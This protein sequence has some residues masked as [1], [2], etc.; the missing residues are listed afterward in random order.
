MTGQGLVKFSVFKSLLESYQITLS[1][2]EKEAIMHGFYLKHYY[3]GD[4]LLA[5]SQVKHGKATQQ[6]H[7]AYKKVD[8]SDYEENDVEDCSGYLGMT[9]R[10]K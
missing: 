6:L 9:I 7:Q 1:E 4:A 2:T 8:L 5:L 3:D 10:P